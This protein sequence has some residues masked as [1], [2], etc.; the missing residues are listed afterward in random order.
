[1]TVNPSIT[2]ST[3]RV[4]LKGLARRPED[5]FATAGELVQALA[6]SQVQEGAVQPARSGSEAST[7]LT[8]MPK[9]DR[10]HEWRRRPPLRS[11]ESVRA[12]LPRPHWGFCLLDLAEMSRRVVP[13]RRQRLSR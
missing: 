6:M 13:S 10:R 8:G 7:L 2:P 4:L 1:S 3:E 12:R 11:L 9:P 5:R